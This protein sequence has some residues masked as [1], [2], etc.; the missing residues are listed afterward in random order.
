MT[1]PR[2]G[3]L[4]PAGLLLCASLTMASG[5][6]IIQT[7]GNID[8]NAAMWGDPAAAPTAGNDYVTAT[9]VTS[10]TVRISAT[11][12]A[13]TFGGDSLTVSAGTRA[14]LKNQNGA[15]STLNGNLVLDGGRLS[16]APNTGPHAGTLDLTQLVVSGTGSLIDINGVTTLT[17]D[18]TLAGSGD[19]L[20]K[21]ELSA[22]GTISITGVGDYTGALT[23]QAPI[24]LD[25]GTDH[26]F[27]NSLT[28][29]GTASLNVDQALTF[30][31][32]NLV[33]NG[34]IV[35]AG[36]YT[37]IDLTGLGSNFVDSGGTLTVVAADADSDGLP[38]FYE[39]QIIA[40]D[41]LDA[42]DGYDDIAGPNNAPATTDF[43]GDG[44][45]DTAEYAAGDA[46][47]QTDPTNPDMDGDGLK[48][49][50]EVAGTNN[51]GVST[52][53]GPTDP[54]NT[55][56]DFDGFDD[57]TEVRYGSDPNSGVM[58][59]TGVTLVN[60]SFEEPVTP[61]VGTAAAVSS[62]TVPGWSVAEN[63]FYVL[64]GFDFADGNNPTGPKEG[65]QFASAD[66]RAPSPDVEP[67]AFPEGIDA[68]MSMKQEIDVSSLATEIDAGTRTF[69]LDF[70]WRDNDTADDG[71][72][73]LEFL[74]GS[75]LN[76]GRST[77]F[78]TANSGAQWAHGRHA[79]Y[80]PVGTRKVRVIA[81]AVK[82]LAG[83]TTIRNIHFDNFTA[84]LVHFDLDADSIPDD[85]E[86]ANG[87]D[88]DSNA[89]AATSADTDGLSNLQE[90]Q[91]GTDPNLA[92]T[93]GDGI[94]DDI[95][96]ANGTDPLDPGSPAQNTRITNIVLTKD[97]S[98][99]VTKVEVMVSGLVADKTYNLVRGTDLSTF[100]T[101]VDTHQATGTTDTFV[102]P[103][104]L[105]GGTSSKAFYRLED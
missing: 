91:Y 7:V 87:L 88:P 90:F 95:E 81:D 35:P 48:D 79:G 75:G 93:D 62:G 102:D 101:V 19:L 58:P 74:D 9:G 33:A 78:R 42:V 36:T 23:V 104:P 60:G 11:G 63:D 44:R 52:G 14:L 39:D 64:T 26:T 56:S 68:N 28:L 59:G 12:T 86:L 21:P 67:T 24:R 97:G 103:A 5:E 66:R 73:T 1:Y 99:V 85:W 72:V 94:N 83:P 49:G 76:L 41:P 20:L 30:K 55:D 69:L 3:T 54:K 18:G 96:V 22:G 98:G 4:F 100:P 84:R 32:G 6:T 31:L 40:F 77:V 34:T 15:I 16:H 50:P 71:L 46:F 105:P 13:S 51:N 61:T 53:F 43:D 38:D 27:T 92:D 8:W 37:G 65:F 57:N 82:I 80:P 89:D 17:I 45:T 29:Q 2:P 70:D 47:A 10:N 25:F